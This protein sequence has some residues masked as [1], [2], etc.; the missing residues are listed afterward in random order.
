MVCNTTCFDLYSTQNV[1]THYVIGKPE[2]DLYRSK[3]VVLK[4]INFYCY[5]YYIYV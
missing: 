1:K 2:D 4:T 5:N 3:H